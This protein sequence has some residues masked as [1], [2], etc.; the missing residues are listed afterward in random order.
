MSLSKHKAEKPV[1]QLVNFDLLLCY[2]KNNTAGETANS[3]IGSLLGMYL[4][5]SLVIY[6]LNY[7]TLVVSLLYN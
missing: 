2:T 6:K 1:L 4:Y 7:F 3:L 5:V